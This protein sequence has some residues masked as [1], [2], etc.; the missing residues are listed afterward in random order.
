MFVC[1]R[2]RVCAYV[3]VYVYVCVW[4]GMLLCV[5]GLAWG[6]VQVV[7]LQDRCVYVFVC[8][9]VC[10]CVYVCVCVCVCV[11]G[12]GALGKLKI[13][14]GKKCIAELLCEIIPI[15]A[16]FVR[17]NPLCLRCV[18]TQF[19]RWKRFTVPGTRYQCGSFS[20]LNVGSCYH[21]LRSFHFLQADPTLFL[22]TSHSQYLVYS[23]PPSLFFFT[24]L[25]PL[26]FS[27][28]ISHLTLLLATPHSQYLVYSV[29]FI[30][31]WPT[32]WPF[33]CSCNV[34]L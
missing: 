31:F 30:F 3:C 22:A 9:F 16:E 26:S 24:V 28:Q 5:C 20:L 7:A 15:K 8:V 34:T 18:H 29:I 19:N 33:S 10:V 21:R 2:V 17:I 25:R 1:V 13:N 12:W 23:S 14:G 4:G 11:R 32:Q 27:S 6:G